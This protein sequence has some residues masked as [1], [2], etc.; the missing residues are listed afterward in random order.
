MY[1]A[2]AYK[3]KIIN[4]LLDNENFIKLLSPEPPVCKR[5]DVTDVLLGGRW[6]YGGVVYEEQGQ[7]FD[8]NFV[9][10]ITSDEK[11]FVFVETDIDTVDRNMFMD[12][13]LYV[14]IFTS[15]NLVRLTDDTS[16][17]VKQVRDMGYFADVYANRVDVLCDI[18]DR[19]LNGGKTFPG[20][21]SLMPAPRKHV[22]IYC[23][24]SKYYGKCLRYRISNYNDGGGMCGN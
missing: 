12:F 21:G 23:P 10:D 20:I 8:Y 15:K 19:I 16:P 6:V 9:S 11:T 2:A 14:C 18:T 4:L 13:N 17:S 7:V 22:T 24:N 3:N 5:L 1:Y